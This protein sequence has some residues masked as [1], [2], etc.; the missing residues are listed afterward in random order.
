MKK[1]LRPVYYK[2]KGFIDRQ[3]NR[4]HYYLRDLKNILQYGLSAPRYKERIWVDPRKI[5]YMID[6]EEVKRVTGIHR[7]QSSAI[8]VDWSKVKNLK[9]IEDQLERRKI[10]GRAWSD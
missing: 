10:M 3:S 9:P 6:R 7:N 8:V 1:L 4:I 5:E 2:T